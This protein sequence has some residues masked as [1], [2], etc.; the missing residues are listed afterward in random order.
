[1]SGRRVLISGASVAGPILGYWLSRF[2]LQATVVERTEELRFGSGGHAVD[3]FG[4]ALQIIEWMGVLPQVQD[5]G[6]HTEIMSFIWDGHRPIDVSAELSFEGVSERHV[7]IMRGELAKIIYEA[8]RED[9]DYMF[10][11]SMT[12]L[13]QTEWGVNVAFRHGLPQTFDLV[14]G[15]DG[16]HSIT[17]RLVFGEEHQ[18]LHFL[19]GYLAVFTV[20]NYLDLNQRMLGYADVGR[21]AAIYPVR[22]TGQAR[23]ILLWP[24]PR[25][26]R[27]RSPRCRGAATTDTHPVQR[28]GLG[29]AAPARR[30]G[31]RRRHIP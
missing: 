8:S 3:L 5:A 2:G 10:G 21:T 22:E 27:L 30:T 17:R 20:P 14:I 26:V 13:E 24:V 31:E 12:S 25:A 6:T 28:H 15:A 7:E 4:P 16:L 29:I 1:V 11:N 23:V 9:I 19:G 18:F